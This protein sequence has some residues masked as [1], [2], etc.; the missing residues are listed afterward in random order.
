MTNTKVLWYTFFKNTE[1]LYRKIKN[2]GCRALKKKALSYKDKRKFFQSL[3]KKGEVEPWFNEREIDET[4]SK[5]SQFLRR[6]CQLAEVNKEFLEWNPVVTEISNT[7][8]TLNSLNDVLFEIKR[9]TLPGEGIRVETEI[10]KKTPFQLKICCNLSPEQMKRHL[11][12]FEEKQ[13]PDVPFGAGNGW[14]IELEGKD[15]PVPCQV[16]EGFWHY[17]AYS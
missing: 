15:A 3:D 6:V 14:G 1:N 12:Y 16:K 10:L 11:Q 17:I 5:L 8:D 13:L 2:L 9:N 4:V 7:M